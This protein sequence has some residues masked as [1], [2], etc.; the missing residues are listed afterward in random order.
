M[1]G[2]LPACRSTEKWG[3][4][5]QC[6]SWHSAAYRSPPGTEMRDCLQPNASVEKLL[7]PGGLGVV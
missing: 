2:P 4:R 5:A 7:Q 3:C 1:L 6:P